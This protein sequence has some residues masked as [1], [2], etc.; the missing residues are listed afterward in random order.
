MKKFCLK[1]KKKCNF[2]LEN[3]FLECKSV[4]NPIT[5]YFIEFLQHYLYN[6]I[7]KNGPNHEGA[8]PLYALFEFATNEE[9]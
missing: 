9:V 7:K 6:Y 4:C 8:Y 1:L 5:K 2:I 3:N